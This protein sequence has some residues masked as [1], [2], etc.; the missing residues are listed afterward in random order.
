M[1]MSKTVYDISITHSIKK[2]KIIEAINFMIAVIILFINVNLLKN[3]NKTVKKLFQI[4]RVVNI[5]SKVTLEKSLH[6]KLT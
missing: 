4:K 5:E 3:F 1:E 2:L 6:E